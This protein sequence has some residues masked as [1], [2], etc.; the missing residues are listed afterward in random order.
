MGVPGGPTE[1]L[2]A[3]PWGLS[4]HHRQTD[5]QGSQGRNWAA[6]IVEMA[7]NNGF[8]QLLRPTHLLS[9]VNDPRLH[10]DIDMMRWAEG[11]I[12]GAGIDVGLIYSLALPIEVLRNR[13]ERQALVAAIADAPSNAIWLKIE[14]FGDD[15][16]GEK[17][18]AYIEA[19]RDFH[20]RGI[21]V[22]GDHVGG[23]PG[24]GALAFGAAGGIAHGVT[25]LGSRAM[26]DRFG[27]S[28]WHSSIC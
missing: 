20:Q 25:V 24:L 6:Q 19:C 12:A 13:L 8:T 28:T 10:R 14:N 21:P 11:E 2:A 5:F 1:N 18:A 26:E 7:V 23:L 22:V 16:T 9:G 4:R 15:A 3:L 17:T 27:G